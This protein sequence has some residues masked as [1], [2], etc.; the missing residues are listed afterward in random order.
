MPF[1]ENS[2]EI[3][4]KVSSRSSPEIFLKVLSEILPAEFQ[5]FESELH[6]FST[7]IF[8][9]G[10]PRILQEIPAWVLPE[11]VLGYSF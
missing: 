8:L 3:L 9:A 4:P 5:V 1:L 6:I 7:N 2:T 11:V 10:F